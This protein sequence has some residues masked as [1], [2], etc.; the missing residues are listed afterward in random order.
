MIDLDELADRNIIGPK[1][2]ECLVGFAL[3][4]MPAD[5]ADKFRRAL[6]NDNVRR[7]ELVEAFS[8][9]GYDIPGDTIGRHRL[10]QCKCE[11]ES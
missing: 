10:K 5:T 1:H 2:Q 4:V 9:H 8:E 7:Y 3:R 6:A 11:R